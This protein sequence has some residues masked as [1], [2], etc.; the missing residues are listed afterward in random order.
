MATRKK[1]GDEADVQAVDDGAV[2]DEAGEDAPAEVIDLEGN[3]VETDEDGLPILRDLS[4][5][6][7]EP[8]E[9]H[10]YDP[11]ST[12]QAII[13]VPVTGSTNHATKMALRAWQ[14]AH[15]LP[16][17]GSLDARTKTAMHL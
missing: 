13:G 1:V 11:M 15:G 12:A 8:V 16:A 10:V 3:P 14:R 6:V 5:P 7:E 17:T 9:A 2:V 4:T